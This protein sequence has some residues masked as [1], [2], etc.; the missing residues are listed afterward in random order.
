MVK[1]RRKSGLIFSPIPPKLIMGVWQGDELFHATNG[2][3]PLNCDDA[4][5]ALEMEHI[6]EQKKKMNKYKKG[7]TVRQKKIDKAKAVVSS[8]EEYYN[9][10]ANMDQRRTKHIPNWTLIDLKAMIKWKAPKQPTIPF[11]RES[12]VDVWNEVKD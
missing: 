6:A 10:K 2:G 3:D 9:P 4:I 8:K 5:I 7:P 1:K 12:L 11:N